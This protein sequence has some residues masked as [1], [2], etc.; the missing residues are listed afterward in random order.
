MKKTIFQ[1]LFLSVCALTVALPCS[2][3]S[4]ETSG[5]EF[6]LEQ[7]MPEKSFITFTPNTWSVCN[8][9]ETIMSLSRVMI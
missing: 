5:K 1:Q 2:A 6:T 4:P 3:Q 9:W 7:L 8:G